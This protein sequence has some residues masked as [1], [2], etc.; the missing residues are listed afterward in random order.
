MELKNLSLF[1]DYA[2]MEGIEIDEKRG[3]EFGKKRG[4]ET[5]F[6]QA[7][8]NVAGIGISIENIS[9]LTGFSVKQV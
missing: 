5:A 8:I 4:M 3:I 2:K 1:T 6:A 7:V 9:S